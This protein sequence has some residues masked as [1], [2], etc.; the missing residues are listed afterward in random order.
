ME[1]PADLDGFHAVLK[2]RIR[3]QSEIE[4]CREDYSAE[5]KVAAQRAVA[6][7]E[8]RHVVGQTGC[9]C[10]DC[11][12]HRKQEWRIGDVNTAIVGPRD[13]WQQ[14][15]WGNA[16][17]QCLYSEDSTTTTKPVLTPSISEKIRVHDSKDRIW[18]VERAAK[19]VAV[20]SG[21]YHTLMLTES[22]VVFASGDNT[23]GALGVAGG[24]SASRSAPGKV[25]TGLDDVGGC[26]KMIAAS[27]F[28]SFALVVLPIPDP[29]QRPTSKGAKQNRGRLTSLERMAR[30]RAHS[31]Q[32][33]ST[34]AKLD[35]AM[36]AAAVNNLVSW[37]RGDYGVLGHGDTESS[38]TPRVIKIFNSMR[39]T[40]VSAGLHHVLVLTEL[41]GVYAFGDGS[42]GKLG[43]GDTNPRLSP[44]RIT[45]LDGLNVVHVSAGDEH[46]VVMTGETFFNRQ[47]Y[48]WGL[49]KNGRLGHNDELTRLKPTRVNCFRGR[50]VITLVAG[51]AHNLATSEMPRGVCVWSWGAGS[52]G[53]LGH[54]DTWD[55]LIPRS[56]DE[57]RY[58]SIRYIDAGQRHSLAI[59]E[60]KQLWL[61]GQ[62]IHG[63]YDVPDPDASS[64][65]ILYPIKI[66][67]PEL[68]LISARAGRGRTFVWGDRAIEREKPRPFGGSAADSMCCSLPEY[69]SLTSDSFR[70]I[71]RCGPC[72][73]D[74]VC[75]GCAHHC[76]IQHCLELR[77]TMVDAISRHCDCFTSCK[78]CVFV[79]DDE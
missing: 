37:G 10:L 61:W 20:A 3:D 31:L 41:D 5:K 34:Q 19:F 7:R 63:D 47:V 8:I 15:T 13:Q 27:G 42:N 57:I 72:Q 44:A 40:C 65:S 36:N 29:V 67:L 24:V 48:S 52:Y 9:F 32:R 14:Y 70:I 2:R 38:A 18:T 77:Y 50:K 58:E 66:E 75:I 22:A 16:E 45:S 11:L 46:S 39:V 54:R 79:E 17:R 73:L 49:G 68:S 35:I 4:E 78:K 33:M 71:Y 60:S 51:G 25:E 76:H 30:G 6:A 55:T 53:Q 59:S 69:E 12:L 23:Y 28:A 43:L 26:V 1:L 62:G 56:V 74:A 21:K 64:S